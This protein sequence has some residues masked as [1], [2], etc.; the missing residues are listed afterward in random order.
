MMALFPVA[1]AQRLLL[2]LGGPAAVGYMNIAFPT[3][4]TLAL[5]AG[6]LLIQRLQAHE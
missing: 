4:V 3:C 2:S 6:C 5:I 1:I